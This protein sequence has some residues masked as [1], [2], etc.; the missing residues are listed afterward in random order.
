MISW[1]SSNREPARRTSTFV[2]RCAPAGVMLV[3]RGEVASLLAAKSNIAITPQ[4]ETGNE[5]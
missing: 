5:K 4:M 3:M 2:P 1:V